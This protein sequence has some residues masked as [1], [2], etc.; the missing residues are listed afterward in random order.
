MNVILDLESGHLFYPDIHVHV[1]LNSHSGLDSGGLW[2]HDDLQM[3]SKVTSDLKFELCGLNNPC[4]SAYLAPKCFSGLNVPE[5]QLSSIDS[6]G[7]KR[8]RS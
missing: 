8:A 6:L 4:S 7:A 3:T 5:R 2:G 1:D